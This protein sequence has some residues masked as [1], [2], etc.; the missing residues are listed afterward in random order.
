VITTFGSCIVKASVVWIGNTAASPMVWTFCR[1]TPD[2]CHLCTFNGMVKPCKLPVTCTRVEPLQWAT[3]STC[4]H[5]RRVALQQ[6]AAPTTCCWD[7]HR[8]CIGIIESTMSDT[9]CDGLHA[10]ASVVIRHWLL[11]AH[12]STLLP[13]LSAQLLQRAFT[14]ATVHMHYSVVVAR[15]AYKLLALRAMLSTV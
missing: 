3:L 13:G 7:N 11:A 14:T 12:M 15:S 5:N 9:A 4:D 8:P 10:L 6:A 1:Q 2:I